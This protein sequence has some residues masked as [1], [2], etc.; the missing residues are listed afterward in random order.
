MDNFKTKH[1]LLII[2]INFDIVGWR[3]L[4]LSHRAPAIRPQS[5]A[6]SAIQLVGDLE[7]VELYH[8]QGAQFN[9]GNI[10]NRFGFMPKSRRRNLFC[11]GPSKTLKIEDLGGLK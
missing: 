6:D 10:A 3:W 1:L 8:F 11:R 4:T 7:K 5:S 2:T 9:P